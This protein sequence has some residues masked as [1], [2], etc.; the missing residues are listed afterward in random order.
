MLKGFVAHKADALFEIHEV[1]GDGMRKLRSDR[2]QQLRKRIEHEHDYFRYKMLAGGRCEIYDAC[3]KIRVVECLY[4]YVLYN[5]EIPIRYVEALLNCKR[6]IF[7]ELYA[8]Y[9]ENEYTDVSSWSDI[10]DFLNVVISEQQK[11]A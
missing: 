6:N 7:D 2:E 8:V 9:L 11:T 4:E 3:N 10:E 5:D 1:E